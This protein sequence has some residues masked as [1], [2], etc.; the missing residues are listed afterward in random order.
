MEPN[1][2]LI[3]CAATTNN[4]SKGSQKERSYINFVVPKYENETSAMIQEDTTESDYD[5]NIPN[6]DNFS[7]DNSD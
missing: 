5:S 1:R 2:G 4:R 7:N 3:A 6:D